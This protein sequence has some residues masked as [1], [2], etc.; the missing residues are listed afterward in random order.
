[1]RDKRAVGALCRGLKDPN[2]DVRE[3]SAKALGK[4]GDKSAVPALIGVFGDS[5]EA[6]PKAAALAIGRI[7][8]AGALPQVRALSPIKTRPCAKP[9]P[10]SWP[11]C[12]HAINKQ[13]IHICRYLY[14]F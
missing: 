12:R 1:M 5:D 14:L 6:I 10:M 11:D 3:Q 9:L 2:E 13:T 8:D 7:G 4:I